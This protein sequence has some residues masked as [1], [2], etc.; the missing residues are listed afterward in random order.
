MLANQAQDQGIFLE[1][2]RVVCPWDYFQTCVGNSAGNI[3]RLTRRANPIA[4]SN[5]N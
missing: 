4:F 5:D 1:M 3:F 2:Y